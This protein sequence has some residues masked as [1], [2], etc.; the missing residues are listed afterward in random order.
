MRLTGIKNKMTRRMLAESAV[1]ARTRM[2][3]AV[4][5]RIEAIHGYVS[6]AYNDKNSSRGNLLWSLFF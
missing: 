4:L 5:R 2:A 1:Q 3:I 6:L